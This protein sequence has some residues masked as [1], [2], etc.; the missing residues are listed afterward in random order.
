MSE[1]RDLVLSSGFLAFGRHLGVLAAVEDAGLEIDAVCGT[2]SG[3]LMGALWCAGLSP[4]EI[5]EEA[6][7]W[8]PLRWLRPN[9]WVWRGLFSMDAALA[10]LRTLLPSSF[11][12]LARPFAVGVRGP[13]R[14]HRLIS[15][16][17]LPEAVMA[18]C[19]MPWIFAGRSL[20]AAGGARCQDG[21]AVDRVGLAS[22]RRWRGGK[23]PTVVHIVNRTA[24]ARDEGD[25]GDALVI[26]TPASGASFLSLGDVGGRMAEARV[27]AAAALEDD[28]RL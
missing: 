12:D 2:S 5:L 21:G 4:D 19:A 20:D 9:P 17:A 8:R 7:R 3:A 13:D 11:S 26:R 1:A 15:E 14:R 22:W 24:G 6:T 23:R 16:G 27:V 25:L 28:L 18:S 10:H